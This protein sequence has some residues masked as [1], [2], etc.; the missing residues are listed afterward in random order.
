M[1]SHG[2]AIARKPANLRPNK[3]NFGCK[4]CILRDFRVAGSIVFLSGM[5]VQGAIRMLSAAWPQV[6]GNLA[7][8]RRDAAMFLDKLEDASGAIGWED[9]VAEWTNIGDAHF[10]VSETNFKKG[11]LNEATDAWLCG[12]T[13]FE[14]ARRLVDEDDPKSGEI[15]AKVDAGIQTFG[16]SMEQKLERA[17]IPHDQGE[18]FGYYLSPVNCHSRVPAVICISREE[19][20]GAAL[21]GR[22][23]PV[24]IGRDVAVLVVSHQDVSSF[25]RG[26][27]EMALSSCFD[28]VSIQPGVDAN[29]IGVYGDGLSAALATNFALFDRRVAAAVCDGGLWEWAWTL[30]SIYQTPGAADVLDER[31]VSAR[32][33]RLARQLRCPALVVAGGRGSVSVSEAIKLQVDCSAARLDLD[34]A[35]P[36]MT[37]TSIG[38]VE[39]FVFSDDYI[40]GWLEHKLATAL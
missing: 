19:E 25:W 37:R 10:V 14:V 16:R 3:Q 36:R 11:Y 1:G 7:S 2:R 24:V 26:H 39:N 32:R 40:F 38:E 21:L 29:R 35:M 8:T 17:L 18:C 33:S 34:L 28:Y 23:L 13:A 27:S 22:L 31:A 9:W 5:A 20:A 12:L 30:G 4:A 15:L 6:L